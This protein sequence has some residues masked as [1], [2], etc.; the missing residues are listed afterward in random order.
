MS[1]NT[2][3]LFLLYIYNVKKL[4]IYNVKSKSEIQIR[5]LMCQ[6]GHSSKS[7]DYYWAGAHFTWGLGSLG[8]LEMT[9]GRRHGC[10]GVKAT[11][12]PRGSNRPLEH[13][14]VMSSES[15]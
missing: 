8:P 1:I 2:L 10:R 3:F 14:C 6:K 4:Y 15:D 11:H 12:R 13:K 5:L 7:L 9:S